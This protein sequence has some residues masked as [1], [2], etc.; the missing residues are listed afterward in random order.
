MNNLSFIEKKIPICILKLFPII[1]EHFI[2]F[3]KIIFHKLFDQYIE[4]IKLISEHEEKKFYNILNETN[5]HDQLYLILELYKCVL[6]VLENPKQ[7][8]IIKYEIFIFTYQIF[9]NIISKV[10]QKKMNLLTQVLILIKGYFHKKKQKIEDDNTT[11]LF[12]CFV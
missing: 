12:R 11:W 3:A 6:N 1:I 8:S 10:F 2:G 5:Y 7:F 9:L 4:D